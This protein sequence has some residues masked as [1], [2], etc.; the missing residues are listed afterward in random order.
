MA[1]QTGSLTRQFNQTV[2][3]SHFV[4]SFFTAFQKSV[5]KRIRNSMY[6]FFYFSLATLIFLIIFANFRS[7]LSKMHCTM[8]EL[9]GL[10][11]NAPGLFHYP[12]AE[13]SIM[14][15]SSPMLSTWIV[16]IVLCDIHF[17]SIHLEIHWCVSIFQTLRILLY[18]YSLSSWPRLFGKILASTLVTIPQPQLYTQYVL[19]RF[20]GHVDWWA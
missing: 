2:F 15:W 7:P 20:H 19:T 1:F 16:K 5:E 8:L 13:M 18:I 4:E 6:K 17:S 11:Y 3:L 10:S 12:V 14:C 9:K